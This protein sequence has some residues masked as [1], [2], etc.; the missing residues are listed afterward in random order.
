MRSPRHACLDIK[1]E[2][3]S[4]ET[5]P[6]SRFPFLLL[7]PTSEIVVAVVADV[8]SNSSSSSTPLFTSSSVS[9]S[10]TFIYGARLKEA[11]EPLQ[12]GRRRR[13]FPIC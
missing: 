13:R 8:V 2:A 4:Q 6:D 3:C 7:F 10:P 12:P 1:G 5:E 11:P 9:F